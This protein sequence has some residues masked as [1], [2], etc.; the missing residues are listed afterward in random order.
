MKRR[1]RQSL[2]KRAK[3]AVSNPNY[4][5]PWEALAAIP[6][7]IEDRAAYIWMQGYDAAQRDARRQPVPAVLRADAIPRGATIC[8]TCHGVGNFCTCCP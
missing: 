5:Q 8:P 7:A 2:W 3:R 6:G 4:L 1:T